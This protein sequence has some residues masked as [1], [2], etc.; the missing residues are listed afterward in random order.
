MTILTTIKLIL[1]CNLSVVKSTVC[2]KHF[3][4][5]LMILKR[6]ASYIFVG[7]LLY[8]C[9]FS[10]GPGSMTVVTGQ[11][12]R[13]VHVTM[14]RTIHSSI[15]LIHAGIKTSTIHPCLLGMA[16]ID[17]EQ[18]PQLVTYCWLIGVGTCHVPPHVCNNRQ[19]GSLQASP[20]HAAGCCRLNWICILQHDT[21]NTHSSI[22]FWCKQNVFVS[23]M[24]VKYRYL[25]H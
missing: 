6:N 25:P 9:S 13:W 17:I 15:A 23:P 19:N 10:V 8:W 5:K 2:P 14:T 12:S 7:H 16:L 22:I 24:S 4:T 1:W 18:F 21:T 11:W 20:H 3:R